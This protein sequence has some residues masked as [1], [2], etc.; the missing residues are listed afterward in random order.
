VEALI[1]DRCGGLLRDVRLFD[2]YRGVPLP[3]DRKSLAFRLRFGAADRTLTEAEVEDVVAAVVAGLPGIDA[4][5]R[6]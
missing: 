2:I 6:T 5:L 1:V 4:H 3:G